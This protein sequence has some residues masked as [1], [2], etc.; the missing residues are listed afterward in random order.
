MNIGIQYY[1]GLVDITID[2][3]TSGQYNRVLYLTAGIPTGKNS[4]KQKRAETAQE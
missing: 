3:A 4:K 1:Y 2:D